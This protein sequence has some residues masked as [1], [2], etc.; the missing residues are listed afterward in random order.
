MGKD[1]HDPQKDPLDSIPKHCRT[2]KKAHRESVFYG[3][4]SA[5]NPSQISR[6]HDNKHQK[7]PTSFAQHVPE[8]DTAVHGHIFHAI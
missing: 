3:D 1:A 7:I 8:Q 5:E 2:Q 6:C 4:S